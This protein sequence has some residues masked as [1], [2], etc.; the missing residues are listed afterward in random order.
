MTWGSSIRETLF[1]VLKSVLA[2]IVG[3]DKK[4]A[5]LR[6]GQVY[7]VRGHHPFIIQ[8]TVGADGKATFDYPGLALAALRRR[9]ESMTDSE[10]MFQQGLVA[11]FG[12]TGDPKVKRA[13]DFAQGMRWMRLAADSGHAGANYEI[14]LV[15]TRYPGEAK[16][17][18]EG[19]A[20]D[21]LDAARAGGDPL[22]KAYTGQPARSEKSHRRSERRR[23]FR[24]NGVT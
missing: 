8:P 15:L 12:V 11:L 19:E 16:P 1:G 3:A 18:Y 24:R 13:P 20:A 2:F 14:Y 7:Y 4:A 17:L 22:A 5:P 23:N 9:A 21:R 10:A 6:H